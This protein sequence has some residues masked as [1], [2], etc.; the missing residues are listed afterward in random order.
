MI[1]LL[2]NYRK[3]TESTQISLYKYIHCSKIYNK[4]SAVGIDYVNYSPCFHSYVEYKIK[5]NKQTKKQI[6]YDLCINMI[7]VSL[8]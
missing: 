7:Q 1:L 6:N 4:I 2:Q 5:S 8:F 3:D